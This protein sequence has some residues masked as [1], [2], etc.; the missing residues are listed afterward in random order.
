[1]FSKETNGLLHKSLGDQSLPL[2]LLVSQKS[3]RHD[4]DDLVAQLF[5]G[6]SLAVVADSNTE[7]ALGA[8]VFRALKSR[9]DTRFVFLT[10]S[11]VADMP[12]AEWIAR[13]TSRCDALIAVGSGTINDLCKYVAFTAGKPYV[14][15]PTAASMNGYVSANASI[16]VDGYKKT[17]PARMPQAVF[18]DLEV[19]TAAPLRMSKSGLGDALARPTA[20]ADWL[21]SHLVLGTAYDETPFRLLQEVEPVLFDSARGIAKRDAET[22][23]LLMKMCLLSGLGMTLA[24]GSYPASQGEHMIAHAH[25]ML[26]ARQPSAAESLPMLHGEEIG[27]TTLMMAQ[28]QEMLLRQSPNLHPKAFPADTMNAL[29]GDKT[30]KEAAEAYRVKADRIEPAFKPDWNAVAQRLEPVM[31]SSKTILGILKAA[32]APHLPEMLGWNDENVKAAVTYAPFLRDR[33]TVLDF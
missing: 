17:L 13:E 23:G 19:I 29:F 7:I 21:M 30:T 24:G 27:V 20:Q 1:M 22:I 26:V 33:F 25:E 11:P 32:E 10:P 14:V 3:L 31:L 16:T 12:T 9:F 28:H 8:Q 18:C 2:P 6:L 4:V 5:S 15:F